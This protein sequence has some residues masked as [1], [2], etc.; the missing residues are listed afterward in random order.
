MTKAERWVTTK[1]RE[2]PRRSS[3]PQSPKDDDALLPSDNRPLMTAADAIEFVR[4]R[5]VVLESAAGPVPSLAVV[6]AGGPI[7]GSWWAH[8]RGREI[9][10]LTRA[11]RDCSDVLVCRLIEGKITYVHQRLWPALVRVS[12]RFP[13]Q[14]LAKVHEMHTA[15][16]RH[17]SEQVAFPG[18]VSR[19]ISEQASHLDEQSA[20]DALGFGPR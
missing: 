19:E 11:V 1:Q 13:L 5:G 18:W 7:H 6:I 17:V 3:S 14:H 12:K 8:T 10:A 9:F 2:L 15:S 16:G 20:L 4:T